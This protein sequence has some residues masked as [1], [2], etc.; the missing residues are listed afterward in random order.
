MNEE[1]LVEKQQSFSYINIY[2]ENR[3]FLLTVERKGRVYTPSN[4]P[5]SDRYIQCIGI[6]VHCSEVC[7]SVLDRLDIA[8]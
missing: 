2:T 4:G 6:H 7:I 3:Y 5:K 1:A 8:A